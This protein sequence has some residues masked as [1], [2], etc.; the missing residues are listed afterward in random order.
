MFFIH[1][2]LDFVHPLLTC[3]DEYNNNHWDK[4][5]SLGVLGVGKA[6]NFSLLCSSNLLDDA[7]WKDS[8][9]FLLFLNK[10]IYLLHELN[11]TLHY[12]NK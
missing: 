7:V 3:Y 12:N 8:T 6:D 10:K 9:M 4:F 11:L 1:Q 5:W 2:D